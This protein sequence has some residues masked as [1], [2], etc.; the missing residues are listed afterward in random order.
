[1]CHSHSRIIS[2]HLTT[3]HDCQT[4]NSQTGH[5]ITIT[6]VYQFTG[7]LCWILEL[8]DNLWI[9]EKLNKNLANTERV[10]EEKKQLRQ[11]LDE[12]ENQLSKVE[13]QRRSLEDEVQRLKMT[14]N[15]KETETQVV[16]QLLWWHR[17]IRWAFVHYAWCLVQ[18]CSTV[19]T[20]LSQMQLD[21]RKNVS[22]WVTERTLLHLLTVFRC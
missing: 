10:E 19:D 15:D 18:P 21:N 5:I 20:W 22:L 6:I 14:I 8:F 3:M 9:Q 11:N 7:W 1:M 17:F 13:F 2:Q 12:A 16:T 4:G